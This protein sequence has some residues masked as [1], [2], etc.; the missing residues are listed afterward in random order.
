MKQKD[1]T[2]LGRGVNEMANLVKGGGLDDMMR[3]LSVD[4]LKSIDSLTL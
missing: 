3:W 1:R 2:G 4:L